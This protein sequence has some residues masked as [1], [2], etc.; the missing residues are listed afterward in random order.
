MILDLSRTQLSC[1]VKRSQNE[2]MQT[3]LE[4]INFDGDKEVSV[5]PKPLTIVPNSAKKMTRRN[6][7]LQAECRIV[8]LVWVIEPFA[9]H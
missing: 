3:T 1:D 2:L 7:R 9:N 4:L 8:S 5:I 6:S